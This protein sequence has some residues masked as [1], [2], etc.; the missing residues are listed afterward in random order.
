[1]PAARISLY[2]A[3]IGA[4]A[5]L[6]RS[7][8]FE[9]IPLWLAGILFSGYLALVLFGVFFL[10]LQMFVDVFYRGGKDDD[11]VA[12]TFDDGPSP[13]TTPKILDE[14]D[15][16][17]AKATFFV[18]GRKAERHPEII[19]DIVQRGHAVGIHGFAHDRLFSLRSLAYVRDDLRR[20]R[21]LLERLTGT[22]PT[23]FRPPIGHSNARIAR[24][25]RELDL[26]VVGWT[27]RA[28]DGIGG[29]RPESVER[30]VIPRL[31]DGE[32]V[33]LH[34]AAE[35]EDFV[36]ASIA[37]LPRILEAMESRNLRGVRVGDW[38]DAPPE[39]TE[40]PPPRPEQP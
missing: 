26:T 27:I 19:A 16:A 3:S 8:V 11:G 35:R 5:V 6:A 23:L 36:P 40:E 12:L 34:D 20:A 22:R 37:A 17:G 29:A 2:V 1:M 38:I 32:V 28:L 21:D 13:V 25:V 31:R 30:R 24:V 9:P 33:L 39:S 18:I 14:L 10:R 15:R 7:L 4:L